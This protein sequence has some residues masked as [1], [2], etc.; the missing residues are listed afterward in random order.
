MSDST[1]RAR[2]LEA[3]LND[4]RS[5]VQE[6]LPLIRALVK[7]RQWAIEQRIAESSPE[8]H[9]AERW[10]CLAHEGT[11]DKIERL[12]ANVARVS[13]FEAVAAA[14]NL[15][16]NLVWCRLL[17][18]DVGY[19]L[20]FYAQLIRE[21]IEGVKSH[22]AKIE[23]EIQL[24]AELESA[25][26]SEMKLLAERLRSGEIDQHQFTAL[27]N[28][29]KADVDSKARLAF[30]IYGAAAVYNGYGYQR[31]ILV[32]SIKPKLEDNLRALNSDLHLFE[33]TISGST[34]ALMAKICHQRRVNWRKAAAEICMLDEYDFVYSFASKMLHSKAIS[35][36]PNGQLSQDEAILMLE[37]AYIAASRMLDLLGDGAIPGVPDIALIRFENE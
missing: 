10:V 16:E 31:H 27:F 14:R 20:V 15:F 8:A 4:C 19:G 30:A 25:E 12:F 17:S 28:D 9:L 22:L 5:L 3:V 13:D 6:K 2:T 21:Q 36:A 23:S 29:A 1:F 32:N 33:I 37:Y 11:L 7:G 26:D 24:F 18:A 34:D 35:T